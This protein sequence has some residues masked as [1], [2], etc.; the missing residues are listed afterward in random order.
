MQDL[1]QLSDEQLMQM[2]NQPD[3]RSVQPVEKQDLSSFSDEQL[4]SMLGQQQQEDPGLLARIADAVTG[5]SR[6]TPEIQALPDW[7]TNMPE[8]SLAQGLPALK[9]SLGT[10]ATGPEETAKI[11]KSNFPDVQVRQDEKGNFIFKSGIDQKEYALKPGLSMSDVPRGIAQML[12]FMPAARATS[13]L[14]AGIAAGATQAAVEGSQAAAGGEFN[15]SEIGLAAGM[16]S[17]GEIAGRILGAAVPG[18]KRVLSGKSFIPEEIAATVPVISKEAADADLEALVNKAASENLSANKYKRLLAER[19]KVDPAAYAAAHDLGVELPPDVFS[20]NPQLRAIVGTQ[21]SIKGSEAQATWRETVTGA[22]QKADE[23][24]ASIEADIPASTVSEN[25]K[26]TLQA[27]RDAL[28]AQTKA[29]YD[30]IDNAVAKKTVISKPVK[31][32]SVAE[33]SP[34]EQQ[35]K[36]LNESIAKATGKYTT[37]VE[38]VPEVQ[39]PG[40]P[41]LEALLKQTIENQGGIKGLTLQ[42][43]SLFDMIKSDTVTYDRLIREKQDLRRTLRGKQTPYSSL[44]QSIVE[45]LYNAISKDQ[46]NAVEQIGGEVLKDR[47]LSANLLYTK[48]KQ[49]EKT[50]VD[51]F[52]KELQGSIA[53]QMKGAVAGAKAGNVTALNKLLETVPENL[54]REAVLSALISSSAASSGERA[55]KIGLT[56]FGNTWDMLSA[57]PKILS[58]IQQVIQPEAFALLS[59]VA[60]V[61]KLIARSSAEISHTGASN[62]AI[63]RSMRAETLMDRL[64]GKTAMTFIGGSLG[65]GFGAAIGANLA[66][67]P[68]DR[69][70]AAAKM[71][72]SPEFQAIVSD[73]MKRPSPS[74]SAV[75]AFARSSAFSKFA[76][77]AKLPTDPN[78]KV[79]WVKAA[80]M[81]QP[82]MAMPQAAFQPDRTIAEVLP[83]GTVKSD[84][85]T[86]F[87]IVQKAGGKFRLLSPDGKVSVF[88]TE[89]EAIRSATRQLRVLT[90]SPLK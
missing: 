12:M 38:V 31:K 40:M 5:N 26:S 24:L 21:R 90:N 58:R 4:Q 65:G 1:S 11:I 10:M 53:S 35:I 7:R 39:G 15:P 48:Q 49:V 85:A 71:F 54:Q 61:G 80:M 50:L 73:V 74:K 52:G 56:Q 46:L 33:L 59:N 76:A 42:E 63:L 19:A 14:G 75:D 20:D 84:P 66:R 9:T 34:D 6:K 88:N 30:E 29:A 36:S 47:L 62:Q 22:L 17:A 45:G 87:K 28:K 64:L 67:I 8:F 43:K 55:S 41:H 51:A 16:G 2:A 3:A 89:D 77:L 78:S 83:N 72:N 32:V 79:R 86:K 13:I 68:K 23:A 57:Q 44:D 70:A 37:P 60:K 69:L 27:E 25:V 82:D 18:V 81:S